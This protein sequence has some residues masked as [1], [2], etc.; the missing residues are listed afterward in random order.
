MVSKVSFSEDNKFILLKNEIYLYLWSEDF[1][2]E[3]EELF[4]FVWERY[5]V[6]KKNEITLF[7]LVI[8]SK[9]M[10]LNILTKNNKLMFFQRFK[11]KYFLDV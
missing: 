7:M 8:F 10:T 3:N 9:F 4:F 1:S 6:K 11:V 5:F 2:E